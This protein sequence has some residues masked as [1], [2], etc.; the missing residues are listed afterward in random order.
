[1]AKPSSNQSSAS[2]MLSPSC[3][4]ARE[5]TVTT[6]GRQ[7]GTISIT[8]WGA[9][10]IGFCGCRSRELRTSLGARPSTRARQW[11]STFSLSGH[12]HGVLLTRRLCGLDPHQRR[13]SSRGCCGR[14]DAAPRSVAPRRTRRFHRKRS[15]TRCCRPRACARTTRTIQRRNPPRPPRRAGEW[16]DRTDSYRLLPNDL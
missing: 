7:A 2:S 14:S 6:D 13:L 10:R 5:A 1:M 11:K 3:A 8:S 9:A 16:T 12:G 4:R 15:C